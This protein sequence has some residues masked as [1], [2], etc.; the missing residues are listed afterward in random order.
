M[1]LVFLHV[2]WQGVTYFLHVQHVLT[3]GKS[4]IEN[5]KTLKDDLIHLN[6]LLMHMYM[7]IILNAVIQT[8]R[9]YN[10]FKMRFIKGITL[11]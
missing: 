2:Q 4:A 8:V 3:T 1:F 7:Y 11:A 6:L 5:T 9:V 10:I